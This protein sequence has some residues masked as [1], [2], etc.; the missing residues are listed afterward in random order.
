MR[1]GARL[2]VFAAIVIAVVLWLVAC[3][4]GDAAQSPGYVSG[5]GTVT[6]WAVGE[7]GEPVELTGTS[8][9]DEPVDVADF[10]GQA[11]L[12]NTWYAACPPCRAEAPDLVA[13]D[14][15]D[16]V[17]VIGINSRDDAA[18]ALAFDRT[19]SVG[20]PSIDDGDGKA[21]AQLQGLVSINAVPTSLILDAEGRVAA[22][23]VGSVEPST[24]TALL[25]AAASSAVASGGA[26]PD[27][28][29]AG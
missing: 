19:F 3:A 22:R 10:R 14:E 25:D 17:Q 21:T 5:D 2:V 12:L 24:L 8:F 13:A 23:I 15:R 29:A 28:E 4:P 27:A 6:E 1:R 26:A 9:E 18:T 11:V 16:D 7:R 20:Y